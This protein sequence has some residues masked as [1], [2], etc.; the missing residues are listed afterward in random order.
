MKKTF[1]C[2]FAAGVLAIACNSASKTGSTGA[3]SSAP[4][5]AKTAVSAD[6]ATNSSDSLIKAAPDTIKAK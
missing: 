4:S 1:F 2:L 6:S 3:D 5:S